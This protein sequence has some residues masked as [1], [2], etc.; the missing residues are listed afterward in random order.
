MF[1]RSRFLVAILL[2]LAALAVSTP[3]FAQFSGTWTGTFVYRAPFGDEDNACERSGP[4]TIVLSQSGSGSLSAN[5]VN[6]NDKCASTISTQTGTIS[7]GTISGGILTASLTSAFFGN[8][9]VRATVSSGALFFTAPGAGTTNEFHAV[10]FLPATPLL[11]PGDISGNWSGTIQS[12]VVYCHSNLVISGTVR[13]T[14]LQTGSTFTATVAPILPNGT[15]NCQLSAPDPDF[16]SELTFSGSISGNS[17]TGTLTGF[18]NVVA[19]PLR[20]A[21]NGSALDFTFSFPVDLPD[22]PNKSELLDSLWTANVTRAATVP[23][24]TITSFA[25]TPTTITAGDSA[26]LSWTTQDATAASI[27]KG[28]GSVAVNGSKS[29]S[30]TV[31]T[32][33]TLTASGPTAPAKNSTTTVTVTPCIQPTLVVSN[34][35]LGMLQAAGGPLPTD[36]F[37]LTNTGASSAKV[38]LT[39]TGSFFT[40]TPTSF[41]IE[42][43]ASQVVSISATTQT[44]GFYPGSSIVSAC[45]TPTG[46]TINVYLRVAAVPAGPVSVISPSGARIDTISPSTTGT[47]SFTNP[48]TFAIEGFVITDVPWITIPV[49]ALSLGAGQTAQVQFTIDRSKRPDGAAPAGGVIGLIS[50]R[51]V[52]TT[53]A[54]A[55]LSGGP[56][57]LTT[58]PASASFSIVTVMVVDSMKGSVINQP[59]PPANGELVLFLSGISSK[60]SFGDLNLSNRSAT[61]SIGDLRMYFGSANTTVPLSKSINL[62]IFPANSAVYF[63]S[64]LKASFDELSSTGSLQLRSA[65]LG[66]V[67]VT[68]TRINANTAQTAFGTALP[69]FRSDRGFA[70]GEKFF[71]P[72]VQKSGTMS[73]TLYVQEIAGKSAT[74]KVDLID[75]AGA[76]TNG[77]TFDLS[78]HGLVEQQDVVLPGRVTLRVTNMSDPLSGGT[79]NG[80]A[81]VTDSA[82]G[83]SFA[84]VQLTTASGTVPL[85]APA[86]ASPSRSLVLHLMNS[87]ESGPITVSA[88]TTTVPARKRAVKQ[89]SSESPMAQSTVTIP[90]IAALSSYQ[91]TVPESGFVKLTGSAALRV[92]GRFSIPRSGGTF[93][94]GIPVVSGR[95]LKLNDTVRF[96]GIEDSCSAT[97]AFAR[98]LTYR[99]DLMLV[100]A[101]GLASVTVRLTLRYVFSAGKV[102]SSSGAVQQYDVPAGGFILLADLGKS[103]IGSQRNSFGDLHNAVLDVEVIGGTG[104]V[105][106]FLK[107]TDNGTGDVTIRHEGVE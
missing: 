91:L 85:V 79:I 20:G 96:T 16:P 76:V 5:F 1:L 67:S 84:V 65:Q 26:V 11:P 63:P 101:S 95:G 90:P 86:F 33:Y 58:A 4:I 66:N 2:S 34:P 27:D 36:S 24:P 44:A 52:N 10:A 43:A 104:A 8:V 74:V 93:G 57:A 105:I 64:I 45:G 3:S 35:P 99:T 28:I 87:Q 12:D 107:A 46:T 48:S 92:A 22:E 100:E 6:K 60:T 19:I 83:D 41:T 51:Y 32:T 94:S 97:I 21:L 15:N 9:P 53:S 25:A 81:L 17:F 29:V 69:V 75:A 7:G 37:T 72:G 98:P 42:A 54:S 102:A 39:Q 13:V 31:T 49:P 71:L 73:T 18:D 40:Q 88:T 62:G 55:A 68:Q 14:V 70:P 50:F 77:S 78:G 82:T 38:T 80:Y 89:A 30:P 47:V 106:P 56:S 61:T 103:L 59:A 23:P